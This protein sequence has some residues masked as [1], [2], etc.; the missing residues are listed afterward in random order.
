MPRKPK[1]KGKWSGGFLALPHV[2]TRH[3]DFRELTPSALKV[4]MAIGS[5][6]NGQNNGDLSCT[7]TTMSKWGGIAPATLAKAKKELVERNLIRKTR[8]HHWKTSG[9][10]CELYGLTWLDL[11]ECLGKDLDEA[12]RP[13]KKRKLT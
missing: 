9:T 6:Y 8:T 3:S 2:L 10:R 12:I 13:W 1:S 4:L 5:Q 11:D 7:K